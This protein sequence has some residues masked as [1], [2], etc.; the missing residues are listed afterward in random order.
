MNGR[1]LICAHVGPSPTAFT[2]PCRCN[3][4]AHVLGKDEALGS[5]PRQGPILRSFSGQDGG[6]TYRLRWFEST[7]EDHYMTGLAITPCVIAM[8]GRCGGHNVTAVEA[9][10]MFNGSIAAFQAESAGSNPTRGSILR[11]YNGQYV[12]LPSRQSG[13]NSL[14]Q[15]HYIVLDPR[16]T[17]HRSSH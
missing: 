1:L 11:S 16:T 4:P 14:S 15:Y 2:K 3:R 13:F 10:L 9:P 8:P 7:L 6:F 5:S 12:G 17:S